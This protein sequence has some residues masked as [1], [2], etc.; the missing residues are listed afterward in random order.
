MSGPR[1]SV[2]TGKAS[3]I[4]GMVVAIASLVL[5]LAVMH[6]L[7]FHGAPALALSLFVA[8]AAGVWTRAADL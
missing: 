4:G 2:T 7:S 3:L 5:C 6:E 1:T 8:A